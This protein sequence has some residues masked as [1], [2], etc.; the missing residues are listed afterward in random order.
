[1]EHTRVHLHRPRKPLRLANVS[2]KKFNVSDIDGPLGRSAVSA[3]WGNTRHIGLAILL[4]TDRRPTP[5]SIP[6]PRSPHVAVHYALTV[7]H[8]LVLAARS[9][10]RP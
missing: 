8:W 1:M 7:A 10:H 4:P 6:I 9:P 2:G 5:P 3:S